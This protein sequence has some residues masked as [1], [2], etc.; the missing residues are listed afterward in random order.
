MR[1]YKLN[2]TQRG[3]VPAGAL[4]S[5]W[6]STSLSKWLST[7]L[8]AVLLTS[9]QGM[10]PR[11]A[12]VADNIKTSLEESERQ[13]SS[14]TNKPLT[15]PPEVAAAL[16]PPLNVEFS[17]VGQAPVERRFDITVNSAPAR[18]F[19]MS[20]V[21]DTPYNM[22]AHPSVKG[23]ITLDLKNVTIAEVMETVRNV[24]GYEYRLIASGFEVLPAKLQSKIFTLDYL[25]V[26]RSGMSRV[27]VSSG[28]MTGVKNDSDNGDEKSSAQGRESVYGSQVNT[29]SESDFWQELRVSLSAIVGG[30]EG[31][32]VVINS[33]SGILVVRAMPAELRAVEE[34]LEVTQNVIQRQV[35]LE[36]KILEVELSDGFQSG[37][38]WSAIGSNSSNGDSIVGGQFGGSSIFQTGESVLVGQTDAL[39][40]NNIAGIRSDMASAFGGMFALSLNIGEFSGFVEFLETQGDVHVL[41]SPR[42]STVN[43][44]KAVIKVGTD[45]FFV[46][47]VN[48]RTNN[49]SS[50]S[51]ATQSVDVELTPFFSGVALDVIPQISSDGIVTL[52]IHPSV[53]E[54]VE[55]IKQINVTTTSQFTIPLAQ[56][57]IRESDS[58]VR[59]RSGQVV[60][61]G[62][63]M[64]NKTTYSTSSVPLLGDLPFV[65][66]LFKHK[67]QVTRKSELVILLRPIVVDNDKVWSDELRRAT[68]AIDDLTQLSQQFKQ[69]PEKEAEASE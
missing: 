30:D 36:A 45:E 34:Y 25:N 66:A 7:L 68:G 11:G 40:I 51:V 23:N 12:S 56:S 41:S 28:Q 50:S 65:G 37:I 57:T 69:Q 22:V 47:D 61:I 6:L 29:Q 16:L 18:S 64:Q 52:H 35:I 54:V 26:K 15:T 9:C 60:V 43:N 20:L 5:R 33:H 27:R 49:A 63:L 3:R 39:N 55:K 19:F 14:V 2:Y 53:N 31:R 48:S 59:A 38:N 46:T 44:Q 21:K 24:Y 8:S 32:Q 1:K 58:I 67:K 17:G 13:S 62:G 10:P 4:F 42:I